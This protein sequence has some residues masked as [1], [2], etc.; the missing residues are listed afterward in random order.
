MRGYNAEA[1]VRAQVTEG[2]ERLAASTG[3]K[4]FYNIN[5]LT[6]A[7]QKAIEDGAHYYT[8]GYSPENKKM[9]G[10]FR[11]IDVRVTQGKY[12]LAYRR[13]YNA[14]ERPEA[15]PNTH[16]NPLADLLDYGL[17]G[18][19]G[20][21]YGVDTRTKD[22]EE[23]SA[24]K[25]AGDNPALTGPVTRYRVDFTIRA[26]DVELKQD[27]DGFRT[28]RLLIGVKA[29][30]RE[31]RAVN[32]EASDEGLRVKESEYPAILKNGIPVH[33]AIDLPAIGEEHLVTAVYD[34]NSGRA[35]TLEVPIATGH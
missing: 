5:D 17:P 18:A 28:G 25:T 23:A 33:L 7:M 26:S 6:S 21:L 14:E 13:G 29:Y 16:V 22:T 8:I 3:G 20:I 2:M 24:A 4:A 9:D 35:G 30:D 12:K 1:G 19:T 32:W 31:G 34:W 15:D 27:G 11:R 10:S